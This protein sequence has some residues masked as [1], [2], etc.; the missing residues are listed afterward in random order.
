MH[1]HIHPSIHPSI[2]SIPPST[3]ECINAY[4]GLHYVAL[5]C[6]T[7]DA[8]MGIEF[9][10][11]CDF[12]RYVAWHCKFPA[13]YPTISNKHVETRGDFFAL[14]IDSILYTLVCVFFVHKKTSR[15]ADQGFPS[16][17]NVSRRVLEAGFEQSSL[18]VCENDA[19][20]CGCSVLLSC[21]S[22]CFA[23]LLPAFPFLLQ[24][25]HWEFAMS[26][27]LIVL[28]SLNCTWQ[29]YANVI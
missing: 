26:L 5:Q 29:T 22:F 13:L 21:G 24:A 17:Q 15:K 20:L 18:H 8:H 27:V 28:G 23:Y 14:D 19:A 4:I 6:T 3:L 16:L 7:L 25:F 10:P 11:I 1:L 12:I 9:A 2:I